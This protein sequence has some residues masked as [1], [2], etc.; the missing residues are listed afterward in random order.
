MLFLFIG[1]KI[2]INLKYFVD[3]PNCIRIIR[4]TSLPM[5]MNVARIAFTNWLTAS[6][7]E[8][9]PNRSPINFHGATNKFYQKEW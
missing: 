5:V 2:R 7:G 6:I 1:Y 9:S 8:S 4:K 3:M